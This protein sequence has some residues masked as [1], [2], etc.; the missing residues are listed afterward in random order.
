M[1]F[2]INPFVFAGPALDPD[3]QAY[4]DAVE[5]E[6][7]QALEGGVRTAIN[8]FVVG[9]KDDGIWSAI[10][11]SCILAGAR[12]LDGALVPLVGTA[13]TNNNFV[14]GDYDRETGL[15]GNGSTKYLNANRNNNS[16]PQNSKNLAVYASEAISAG[17]YH[18]G[19]TGIGGSY[20]RLTSGSFTQMQFNAN[21]NQTV[22]NNANNTGLIGISRNNSTQLN[23]YFSGTNTIYSNASATPL[24][25]DLTIFKGSNQNIYG[26]PRLSFYSIGESIDLAALD[27]RVSTLMTDLA[28]A[29]P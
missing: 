8:D 28:A 21:G 19:A 11:A 2:V 26:N 10:K 9:C 20:I 12:T 18:L 13:P 22:V 29:I 7:G 15:K 27:T 5:L 17:R 24:D 23:V 3:A 25:L 4:I 6:D 1:S 14:S 16:E